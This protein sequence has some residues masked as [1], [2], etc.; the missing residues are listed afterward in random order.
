MS[1]QVKISVDGTREV[2]QVRVNQNGYTLPIATDTDLGGIKSSLD[3]LIDSETG[4]ATVNGSEGGNG[5]DDYGKFAKY[6]T[7]GES[8]ASSFTATVGNTVDAKLEAGQEL[9]SAFLELKNF[10]GG[11]FRIFANNV[12]LSEVEAPTG[13]GTLA[14]T[15]DLAA[16]VP[17]TTTVNGYPLSGNV[18]L[19]VADI[20]G[21]APSASPTFT[22]TI[23]ANGTTTL[24]QQVIMSGRIDATISGNQNDWNP[25]GLSTANSIF[26]DGGAADRTITGITGGVAGRL[27]YIV[28]KGSTNNLVLSNS[29]SSS[30]AANR[31]S[32]GGDVILPP[33]ITICLRYDGTANVWRAWGRALA[34][35]GVTAGSYTNAS[36]T[37]DA[38]GRI[39]SASSGSSSSTAANLSISGQ[40]GLLSFT[41][42]TSTNRVKT[43]RDAA[44]TLLELGGSYSPSG[45]WAFTSTTRPTSSGTGAPASTS[46][47]TKNDGDM[48][49][50]PFLNLHTIETSTT[51]L[52]TNTTSGGG[53]GTSARANG[54]AIQS[55]SGA[56]FGS[57]TSAPN[58]WMPIGSMAG[59]GYGGIDFTKT[60]SFT[61]GIWTL[62]NYSTSIQ[63]F[64]VI[65]SDQSASA[66]VSNMTPTS[67]ANYVALVCIA[68]NVT[69]QALKSG[70]A[71]QTSSTLDTFTTGTA[72]Y[73]SYR[74]VI[75]GGTA[76]LYN[77]STALGSVTGCPTTAISTNANRWFVAATASA[78]NAGDINFGNMK[79][80]WT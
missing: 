17:T 28:N 73:K 61:V 4:V 80:W 57:I 31:F 75:S 77:G 72:Q 7:I 32:F 8:K 49:Y 48:T 30:T 1:D 58:G 44:D 52:W 3:I 26:I 55:A 18:T 27:I 63:D 33:N 21:A 62:F 6:G 43:V 10:A 64:A 37:V 65:L 47:I 45:T 46:L 16:Y 70:S 25:T 56:S 69:L 20:S 2:V 19:S 76:T 12:V 22:G 78:I 60:I 40:T 74:V 42:L 13:S 24:A 9:S 29:S 38:A 53:T 71:K 50:F 11:V 68:G 36:I 23:T 5:N 14:L 66:G 59:S 79:I 39:T 54:L 41:G 34:N 67:A 15:S 35:T 51:S